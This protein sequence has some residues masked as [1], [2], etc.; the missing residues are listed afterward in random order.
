LL[1]FLQEYRN[2]NTGAA[3]SMSFII[4]RNVYRMRLSFERVIREVY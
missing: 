2:N 3:T 1:S 4:F